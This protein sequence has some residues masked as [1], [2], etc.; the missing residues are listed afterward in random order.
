MSLARESRQHHDGHYVGAR[1]DNTSRRALASLIRALSDAQAEK[2]R[3]AQRIKEL[4]RSIQELKQI[5]PR[6]SDKICDVCRENYTYRRGR[7]TSRCP[8]CRLW[9]G[10]YAKRQCLDCATVF[11]PPHGRQR[12]CPPCAV[13]WRSLAGKKSYRRRVA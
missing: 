10:V 1:D 2:R 8:R 5:A 9:Y 6:G 12:R 13:K 3:I 11:I 7:P 4:R